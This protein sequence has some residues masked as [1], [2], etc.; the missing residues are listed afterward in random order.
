MNTKTNLKAVEAT[1][2]R[3]VTVEFKLK[4]EK[5]GSVRYDASSDDPAVTSCYVMKKDLPKPYPQTFKMQLI[6][7]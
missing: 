6:F 4:D 3:T 2:P 5:K 1:E 7:D